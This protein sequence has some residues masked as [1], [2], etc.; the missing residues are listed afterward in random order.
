VLKLSQSVLERRVFRQGILDLHIKDF[1]LGQTPPYISTNK[2]VLDVG[3][4]VGMYTSF[5]AQHAK[6]VHAFEAVPPVY[7]QLKRVESRTENI[8][9]YNQA[10]S[11]EVG[12]FE[13]YVDDQRLSNS[14]FQNLVGG[15]KIEVDSITIDSMN[16]TDIGFIKIDTEGTEFEVIQGAQNTIDQN[17]P[18]CMVEVYSKFSKYPVE[19]IFSFFLDR[20]YRCLYNNKGNGLV[21][22]DGLKNLIK[23]AQDETM[24]PVHDGDFLFINK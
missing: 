2:N 22:V 6:H 3:A 15:Q 8:T 7:S 24:L 20:G 13:F 23:V 12:R 11:N 1:M 5:F 21:E 4:A 16:F 18:N 19:K 17:R 9:A 10:V 14:S